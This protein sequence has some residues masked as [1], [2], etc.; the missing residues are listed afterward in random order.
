MVSVPHQNHSNA[1]FDDKVKTRCAVC[2]DLL[3]TTAN[4]YKQPAL[5]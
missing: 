5:K 2:Y 1:I 3:G 4:S